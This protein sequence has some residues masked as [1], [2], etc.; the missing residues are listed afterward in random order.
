MVASSEELAFFRAVSPGWFGA[1]R[2]PLLAGRDF[3]AGDY[4]IADM[5]AFPWVRRHDW[6]GVDL[7]DYP[8][9]KAWF[10]CIKA[11]DAVQRA[12][13]ISPDKA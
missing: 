6:Q 2:I 11:R 5:A 7:D 10:E 1:L 13:A 12:L 8:N 9:V 3:L 4:S